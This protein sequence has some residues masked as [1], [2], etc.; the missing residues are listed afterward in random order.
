MPGVFFSELTWC[1]AEF[2]N[3][4]ILEEINLFLLPFLWD[5]RNHLHRKHRID[6]Q[7]RRGRQIELSVVDK[8]ITAC[9]G[10]CIE[11][12]GSSVDEH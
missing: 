3:H 12:M 2:G 6:W 1:G 8:V 7:A 10:N 5:R 9:I 4:R 11:R